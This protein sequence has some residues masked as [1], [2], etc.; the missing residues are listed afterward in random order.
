MNL[1]KEQM[2]RI[3]T[4]CRPVD[5]E[6]EYNDMLN[7]CGDVVICNRQYSTSFV[8]KKIDPTA[9]RCGLN[10]Y[11]NQEQYIEINDEFYLRQD[12]DKV[13]NKN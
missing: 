7:Y 1:T 3:I 10:N 11:S 8:L 13:L 5:M 6:S 9:Y 2:Q 12:V 4:E